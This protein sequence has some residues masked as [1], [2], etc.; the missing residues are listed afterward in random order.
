MISAYFLFHFQDKD[1]QLRAA[2]VFKGTVLLLLSYV[3][4]SLLFVLCYVDFCVFDYLFFAILV[5]YKFIMELVAYCLSV[6][7]F[8]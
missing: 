6:W 5:A 3:I 2:W 8:L 7:L 1:P 4:C